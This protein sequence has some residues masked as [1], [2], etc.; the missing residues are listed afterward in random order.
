MMRIL[1]RLGELTH[2]TEPRVEAEAVAV[3]V[4]VRIQPQVR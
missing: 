1:H 2:Q 4:E 3:D